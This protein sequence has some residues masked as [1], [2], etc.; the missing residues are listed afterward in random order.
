[1]S[2]YANQHP[3]I[4][5]NGTTLSST[6]AGNTTTV[7]AGSYDLAIL[8]ISYTPAEVASTLSIQIEAG[9]DESNLFPINA[10]ED[11][12]S[13]VSQ[14]KQHIYEISSSGIGTAVKRRIGVC[15]AD[16]KLRVSVKET[17][18]SSFGTVT[19][20]LLRNEQA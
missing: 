7:D 16:L 6:Y 14:V 3:L 13:G 15:L 10:L 2:Y 4:L 9:Y 19:V 12:S 1:M 8:Y 20:A 5:L 11:N 17:V 18:S